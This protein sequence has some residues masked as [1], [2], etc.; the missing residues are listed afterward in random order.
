MFHLLLGAFA[1]GL[2]GLAL[3]FIVFIFIYYIWQV[4][5]QI[6]YGF[7]IYG[8]TKDKRSFIP[9]YNKY[10]LG[11]NS[12]NKIY[13]IALV[14][15]SILK[16]FLDLWILDGFVKTNLYLYN[17]LPVLSSFFIVGVYILYY[18]LFC[19][20]ASKI[21]EKKCQKVWYIILTVLSYLSLGILIPIF[22]FFI[23]KITNSK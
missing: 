22:I 2:A 10:L 17:L 16:L 23:N 12:I 6:L 1:L 21:Y 11:K 13:G 9:F 5:K 4:L 14:I 19:I 18:L 20:S 3:F 7:S 8:L 15:I